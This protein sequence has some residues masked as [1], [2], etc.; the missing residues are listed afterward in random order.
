LTAPKLDAENA[1]LETLVKAA[2]RS[3]PGTRLYVID[4]LGVVLIAPS[5][6]NRTALDQ[7]QAVLQIAFQDQIENRRLN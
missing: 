7:A 5:D 6:T 4:E 1:E 3:S 2:L